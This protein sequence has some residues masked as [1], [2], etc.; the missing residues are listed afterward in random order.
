MGFPSIISYRAVVIATVTGDASELQEQPQDST[1]QRVHSIEP[2]LSA[3]T[4]EIDKEQGSLNTTLTG[5]NRRTPF[6]RRKGNKSSTSEGALSASTALSIIKIVP[7]P[8]RSRPSFLSRVVHRVV[9]CVNSTVDSPHNLDENSSAIGEL[10]S[11]LALKDIATVNQEP[12]L[13]PHGQNRTALPL[14]TCKPPTSNTIAD[15]VESS[16]PLDSDVLVPPPPSTHLLPEEETDGM[17]SGAVQ[18]P[19]STGEQIARSHTM[20]SSEDSDGTSYTDDDID[21]RQ[22][23]RDEQ[24]EEDRLIRNG[25]SGIPIGHVCHSLSL[26][27]KL[28]KYLNLL[29]WCSQTFVTPHCSWIR[30]A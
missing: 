21:H 3:H 24:D 6:Y 17:T 2:G 10:Q 9:P 12:S 30:W 11:S 19:G 27:F 26:L 4:D 29:G 8:S 16:S 15:G 5:H 22:H 25:G 20:D 28:F 7:G 13:L 14:D 23:M 18:P 1:L